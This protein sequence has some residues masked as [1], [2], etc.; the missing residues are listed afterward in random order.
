MLCAVLLVL[1]APVAVS[2]P[3]GIPVSVQIIPFRALPSSATLSEPRT[4]A[5][6]VSP[7]TPEPSRPDMIR[8]ERMLAAAALADPDNRQTREVLFGLTPPDQVAQL[9]GLEAMEQVAAWNNELKPDRLVAYAME[10]AH[11]KGDVFSAHGAVVHSGHEWFRLQFNCRL[12]PDRES[13]LAFE[14]SLGD[15]IPREEWEEHNIPNEEW[16]TRAPPTLA[17]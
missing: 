13:V 6:P 7:G 8:P 4:G 10:E 11:M 3:E 12:A 15:A 1:D 5:T 16:E 9:C 2:I 14:F 17:N